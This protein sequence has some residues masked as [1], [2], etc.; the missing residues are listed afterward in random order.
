MYSTKLNRF[1]IG[2]PSPYSK[3]IDRTITDEKAYIVIYDVSPT[4]VCFRWSSDNDHLFY[5]VNFVLYLEKMRWYDAS[6]FNDYINDNHKL[7]WLIDSIAIIRNKYAEKWWYLA[8]LVKQLDYT[9]DLLIAIM[10]VFIQY[11][12]RLEIQLV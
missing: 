6:Y 9:K 12:D 10:R 1:Q 2:P 3:I 4:Y 11:E 8:Q 7:R 5:T